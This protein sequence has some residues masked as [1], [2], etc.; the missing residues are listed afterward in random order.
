[1]DD[2]KNRQVC[3]SFLGVPVRYKILLRFSII[4]YFVSLFLIFIFC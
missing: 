1:M 3:L 2:E 4:L